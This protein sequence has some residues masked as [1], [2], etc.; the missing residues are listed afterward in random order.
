MTDDRKE[1]MS[2]YKCCDHIKVAT[3]EEY[4]AMTLYRRGLLMC[5]EKCYAEGYLDR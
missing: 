2:R 5:C 1:L 3:P 4:A